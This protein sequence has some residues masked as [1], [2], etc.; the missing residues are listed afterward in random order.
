[1][2]IP[3]F[4]RDDKNGE[5]GMTRMME[6]CDDKIREGLMILRSTNYHIPHAS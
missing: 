1:M 4:V 5:G 6:V 3:H 2:Q